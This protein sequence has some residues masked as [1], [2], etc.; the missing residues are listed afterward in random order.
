MADRKLLFLVLL[1]AGPVISFLFGQEAFSIKRTEEGEQFI[2]RLFWDETEY[3]VRYEVRIEEQDSAGTYTEILRESR[4][5]NFIELSLAP[6]SYRYQVQAFNILNRSSENSEW[7]YFKVLPAL[8]PE[9]YSVTQDFSSSAKNSGNLTEII[10]Q[11]KNLQEADV[12]LVSPETA[13]VRPLEYLLQED[14]VRLVFDTESLPPGRYRVYIRNPGGLE[15]SLE[16]TL[17]PLPPVTPETTSSGNTGSGFK[18]WSPFV[19]VEYA[20]PI[21]LYGYLF[22]HFGKTFYPLGIS[23]RFG[24]LPFKKSWGDLGLEAAPHWTTLKTDFE[25]AKQTARLA[26]LHLNGIYQKRLSQITALN[27]RLGG[28]I[29][30]IYATNKNSQSSESIFTWMPSISA[31]LTLKW[32]IYK[33]LYVETGAEYVHIFSVDSPPPGYIKPVIGAGLAF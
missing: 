27:V 4:E 19:S 23:L 33:S 10:L 28:G 9:L 17:A 31:G 12:Y 2:Q 15:S 13:A 32:F 5:E 22:D 20:P 26:A 24:V 7:V 25:D 11:G 16:I 6:G 18:S 30:F 29:S 3:A 1:M 21:P 8:Q 14:G